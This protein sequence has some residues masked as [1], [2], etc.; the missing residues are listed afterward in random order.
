MPTLLVI[1]III[2]ATLGDFRN[3]FC[4]FFQRFVISFF[5]IT[6]NG[7]FSY[8]FSGT[9]NTLEVFTLSST[10]L[11]TRVP[12]I[13]TA[14]GAPPEPSRV[15]DRQSHTV[16]VS[17]S[18]LCF[19]F[20][21]STTCLIKTHRTA[22]VH[23]VYRNLIKWSLKKIKKKNLTPF[24]SSFGRSKTILSPDTVYGLT[25]KKFHNM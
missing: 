17:H 5:F 23:A 16:N 10:F 21:T 1:T 12:E 7:K 2:I 20:K 6:I 22:G 13:R 18:L 14:I 25:A 4:R 24:Y 15:F 11:S 8:N 9:T 3:N 19:S